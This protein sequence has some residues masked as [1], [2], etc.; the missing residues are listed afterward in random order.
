M[1]NV[2]YANFGGNE[3]PR[4][5]RVENQKLGH[6]S[7]FRSLLSAPWAKDT[8]KLALWVR[9]IG[10]ATHRARRVNFNSSD[11][12]L[13]PGQLVTKF[14]VLS[15]SLVDSEG[16][17]KS[18]QAVR[19][20]LDFFVRE[21]MISYAGNRHGTIISILN[22]GEYQAD[23][24]GGK[25][26]GKSGG[27]KASNDAGLKSIAGGKCEG[28]PGGQEQEGIKQELNTTPKSP[29]GSLS[30]Q[31]ESNPEKPKRTRQK[32]SELQFDH[33]RFMNTWNCKAEKFGLPKITGISKTTLAGITRLYDSHVA[34]C[35]QSGSEPADADTMINGY[36]EFGYTPTDYACGNNPN[37]TKYGLATA[38][39]QKKIDEI[40]TNEA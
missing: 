37:G 17:E 22:Y 24:A 13:L 7:V 38:L 4:S 5:V 31:E 28:Y 8:A 30:V 20:M 32:K 35:K 40:L 12:D 27:N 14:D 36:I 9:L 11:W 25:V 10:Q 33:Q 1:S 3:A 34:Y 23:F 29:E 39:T 19:R 6:F 16:K 18:T 2:A 21:G 26:E 15:R